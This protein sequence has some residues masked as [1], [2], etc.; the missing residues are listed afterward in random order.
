LTEAQASLFAYLAHGFSY[1]MILVLTGKRSRQNV[2]DSRQR[3]VKEIEET[4][5][6]DRDEFLRY[7]ANRPTRM[8]NIT[9]SP[10]K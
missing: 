8:K 3:L 9:I 7:L 5:P 4:D 2:Y 10:G 6:E 1:T